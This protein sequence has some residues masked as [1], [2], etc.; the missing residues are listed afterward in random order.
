MMYRY[1]STERLLASLGENAI[2]AG[3]RALSECANDLVTE[4]KSR[5]PV[6]EGTDRRVVKGALRNSIYAKKK[7]SGQRYDIVADAVAHDGLYYGRVVEF[8]PKI[9]KPFL[10]PAMDAMR[11]DIKRKIVD[12]VK[13][14]VRGHK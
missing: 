6:Y 8:S 1:V 10:Y 2:R 3:H 4:A 12:A 11:D 9:N 13:A 7:R 5:C 14:A